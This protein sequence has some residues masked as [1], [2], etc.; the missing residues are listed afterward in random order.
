M[1]TT[2]STPGAG[3][4]NVA[5]PHQSGDTTVIG[6]SCFIDKDRTV[7]NFLGETYYK[8]RPA[9]TTGQGQDAADAVDPWT[10]GQ[11]EL[12]QV[13]PPLRAAAEDRLTQHVIVHIIG[14]MEVEGTLRSVNED[15]TVT[16]DDRSRRYDIALSSV[17][18]IEGAR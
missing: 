17:A 4:G 16:V 14:G 5:F 10:A 13:D 2:G 6:P 3:D 7:I 12:V 8:A 1:T 9:D 18:V 15:L 11:V